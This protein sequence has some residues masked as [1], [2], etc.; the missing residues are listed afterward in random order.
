MKGLG[1]I[2]EG[3]VTFAVVIEREVPAVAEVQ[4]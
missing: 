1:Q 3:A 2:E 4:L